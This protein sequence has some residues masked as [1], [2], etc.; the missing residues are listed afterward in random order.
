MHGTHGH[1]SSIITDAITIISVSLGS[2]T[3]LTFAI[4]LRAVATGNVWLPPGHEH[5]EVAC[6]IIQHI[7]DPKWCLGAQRALQDPKVESLAR[8]FYNACIASVP[9]KAENPLSD[10]TWI[11][12]IRSFFAQEQSMQL[13]ADVLLSQFTQ[14]DENDIA[15]S[16]SAFTPLDQSAIMANP[17]PE[18]NPVQLMTPPL[19]LSRARIATRSHNGSR[20]HQPLRKRRLT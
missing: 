7:S 6:N 19:M 2:S 20:K 3:L 8:L 16:P 5:S 18:T 13:A 9:T 1:S 10:E 12:G 15:E 4:A 14:P 11:M 17:G